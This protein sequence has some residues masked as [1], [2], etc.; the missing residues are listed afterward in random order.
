MPRY[1]CDKC[2]GMIDTITDNYKTLDLDMWYRLCF[3]CWNQTKVF[4]DEGLPAYWDK[5]SRN[6]PHDP[7]MCE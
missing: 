1:W 5:S 2:G 6:D 4:I 7:S 3:T